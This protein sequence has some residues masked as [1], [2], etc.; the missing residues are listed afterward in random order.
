MVSL[1]LVAAVGAWSG[2]NVSG[3]SISLLHTLEASFNVIPASLLFGGLTVLAFGWVPRATAYVA[4][5]ARRSR[6]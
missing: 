5:A 1:A 2:A 3:A 6:S 4:S